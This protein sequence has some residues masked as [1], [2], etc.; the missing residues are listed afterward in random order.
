MLESR[1]NNSPASGSLE[2]LIPSV[3]VKLTVNELSVVLK[4]MLLL[5]Q[6]VLLYVFEELSESK[7]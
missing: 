6:G 7:S 1:L 3:S 2:P 4:N 5:G